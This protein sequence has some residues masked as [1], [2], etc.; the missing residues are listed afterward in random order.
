MR[1]ALAVFH[2]EWLAETRSPQALFA[3]LLF[4]VV[5]VV[6]LSLASWG[7]R[8]GA[9]M[10]AG[11]LCTAVAFASVCTLPRTFLVEEDQ[12]TF[13]HLRMTGRPG[14]VFMGKAL[15]AVMSGLAIAVALGLL[16]TVLTGAPVVSR[17]LFGAGLALT[18]V[19]VAT[20]TSL[21]GAIVLGSENRWTLV[22]ALSLP[23]LLPLL[24]L[25]VGC[26]RAAFGDGS[27]ETGFQSLVGLA[28]WA[29]ASLGGSPWI[30]SQVWRLDT[31]PD[32]SE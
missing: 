14:A 29:V 8:P 28:G 2:K 31:S 30:V 24:F 6:A 19:G 11:M 18:A 22:A 7:Q 16:F 26:L 23:L 21:C 3:S 13:D 5:T 9:G 32:Q 12:G 17:L 25:S 4:S 10:A 20:A 27:Q 15:F 1:E